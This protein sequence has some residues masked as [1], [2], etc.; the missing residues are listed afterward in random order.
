MG[1]LK[2][3]TFLAG[4][5]VRNKELPCRLGNIMKEVISFGALRSSIFS[6]EFCFFKGGAR[7]DY[8]SVHLSLYLIHNVNRMIF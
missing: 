5:D 4:K 3:F 8:L 7:T 1:W 2:F 6:V